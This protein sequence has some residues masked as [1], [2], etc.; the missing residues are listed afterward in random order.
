MAAAAPASGKAG[1]LPPRPPR[2][3]QVS[4]S[5]LFRE[6]RTP[7]DYA[8]L[9]LGVL[10]SL[11]SGAATLPA[12]CAQAPLRRFG[13]RRAPSPAR[14]RPRDVSWPSGRGAAR[15]GAAAPPL[16]ARLAVVVANSHT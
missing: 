15:H 2:E 11:G 10:G 9:C 6:M 12:L 14:T 7:S 8:L 5:E 1:G 4:F 3:E 13:A 16:R